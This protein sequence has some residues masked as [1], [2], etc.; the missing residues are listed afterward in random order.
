MYLK[1]HVFKTEN[2]NAQSIITRLKKYLSVFSHLIVEVG[3]QLS[4]LLAKD[5]KYKILSPSCFI[6]L[7]ASPKTP[8]MRSNVSPLM[9]NVP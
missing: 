8:S 4:T 7:R 2:S 3:T 6:G 5:W 9:W 1:Y